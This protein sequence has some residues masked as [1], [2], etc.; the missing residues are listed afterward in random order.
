MSISLNVKQRKENVTASGTVELHILLF[1]QT[2]RPSAAT[3][4]TCL[5]NGIINRKFLTSLSGGFLS[6][7]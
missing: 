3:T 1:D 6:V 7:L 5:K 2:G 4:V